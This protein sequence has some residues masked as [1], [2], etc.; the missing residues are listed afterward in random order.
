MG[1]RSGGAAFG[2]RDGA[3]LGLGFALRLQLV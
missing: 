1:F 3:E 2:F